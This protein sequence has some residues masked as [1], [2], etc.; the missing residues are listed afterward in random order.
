MNRPVISSITSRQTAHSTMRLAVFFICL[1]LLC[2]NP[3]QAHTPSTAE[4]YSGAGDQL[5]TY[6]RYLCSYY[7]KLLREREALPATRPLSEE[8]FTA[9]AMSIEFIKRISI[10]SEKDSESPELSERYNELKSLLLQGRIKGDDDPEE[11]RHG[12]KMTTHR[13]SDPCDPF[14]GDIYI[15]ERSL[16]Q[17]VYLPQKA[18]GKLEGSDMNSKERARKIE[19]CSR[20][21]F[22][23]IVLLSSYLIHECIHRGQ[24]LLS[25]DEKTASESESRRILTE[26]EDLAYTEQSRFLLHVCRNTD[27]PELKDRIRSI[28]DTIF[29]EI[30]VQFPNLKQLR[31][32]QKEW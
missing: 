18:I 23:G 1:S 4:S 30:I 13:P 20:S 24:H 27:D 6:S 22:E 5:C 25:A 7:G 26:M 28:A 8:E 29:D 19:I 2:I 32:M 17:N 12:T 16:L 3:L 31:E 21:L 11:M 9:V 14:Q 15:H 10:E